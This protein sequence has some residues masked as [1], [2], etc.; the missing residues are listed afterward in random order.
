LSS[1]VLGRAAFREPL[2]GAKVAGIAII[3]LGLA[4]VMLG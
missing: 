2:T 1:L 3:A 4:L